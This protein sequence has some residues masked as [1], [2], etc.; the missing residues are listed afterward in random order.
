[1]LTIVKLEHVHGHT[2][3]ESPVGRAQVSDCDRGIRHRDFAMMRRDGRVIDGEIIALAAAYPV[4]PGL[5]I[6][7]PGLGRARID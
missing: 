3:D 6:D 2:L 1:M 5:K 4:E 7:L